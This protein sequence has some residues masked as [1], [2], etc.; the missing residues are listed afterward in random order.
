MPACLDGRIWNWSVLL[1]QQQS[2]FNIVLYKMFFFNMTNILK[3]CSVIVWLV[4]ILWPYL[5]YYKSIPNG[6]LI[7][8]MPILAKIR[9]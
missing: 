1:L 5:I 3:S 7:M 8:I 6:I 9:T 2:I 4:I